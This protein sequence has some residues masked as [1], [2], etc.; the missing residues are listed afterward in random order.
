[1]QPSLASPTTY[2]NFPLSGI[3]TIC[4]F[5]RVIH[6]SL[7]LPTATRDEE[8]KEHIGVN[9][10]QYYKTE[11]RKIA[12]QLKGESSEA[13]SGF[14]NDFK[15]QTRNYLHMFKNIYMFH[16]NLEEKSKVA[17]ILH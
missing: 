11:E 3:K 14:S 17:Q 4:L 15:K 2:Q 10:M 8:V 13:D 12:L 7:T 9:S 1:M 16:I 6:Y 5:N